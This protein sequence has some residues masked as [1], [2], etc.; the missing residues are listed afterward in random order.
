MSTRGIE[1]N[2]ARQA[3]HWFVLL[4]GD[5]SASERDACARWRASHADHERAW[6]LAERFH[7]QLGDI[8]AAIGVPALQRPRG[9]GLNEMGR[10]DTLK[11]LALLIA[12]APVGVIGY[13]E[14]PWRAWRADVRTAVG[15]RRELTLPD[16]TLVQL[17]TDSALDIAFDDE[18]R[19][20]RLRAGEMLV[21]SGRDSANRPLLVETCEGI[22][23][24]VGTRFCVRQLDGET[25]VGVLEGAVELHPARRQSE[26]RLLTAGEQSHFSADGVALPSPLQSVASDWSRGVLRAEK[27]RLA[28]FAAELDRYRPGLLRCDP[29]VADLKISGAFQLN[30]TDQA[31]AAVARTLPVAIHYRTHYWVTITD[32]E[33]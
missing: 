21:S 9:L 6:R 5:A 16:G 18:R 14:L 28:D 33:T 15:E 23:R 4:Q 3:S 24:P 2:I 29:A 17:N 22:V 11:L 31:L 25:R 12:A 20:L 8:P 27:M 10:R 19:L 1:R 32:R 30:D 26:L 13:R 7:A